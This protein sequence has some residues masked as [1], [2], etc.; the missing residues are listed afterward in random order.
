MRAARGWAFWTLAWPLLAVGR[1][2]P[3]GRAF[4]AA[5]PRGTAAR[6]DAA[7]APAAVTHSTDVHISTSNP[8][9][10]ASYG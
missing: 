6:P 10:A 8:S 5:E 9:S 7:V 4:G 3:P 1:A 2:A